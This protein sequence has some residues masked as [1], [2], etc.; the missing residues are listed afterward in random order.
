VHGSRVLVIY[1][2]LLVVRN[3]GLE[4]TFSGDG[5][6]SLAGESGKLFGPSVDSGFFSGSLFGFDF[7]DVGSELVEKVKNILNSIS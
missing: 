4:I 2:N 6:G 1:D 3:I 5:I 7:F